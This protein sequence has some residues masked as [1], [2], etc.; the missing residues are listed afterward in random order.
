[1]EYTWEL[2]IFSLKSNNTHLDDT[3]ECFYYKIMDHKSIHN[4]HTEFSLRSENHHFSK[5]ERFSMENTN[6]EATFTS[7]DCHTL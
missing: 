2:R 4:G 5:M 1:M 3:G 6:F 7:I